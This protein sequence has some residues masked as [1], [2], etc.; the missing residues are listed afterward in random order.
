MFGWRPADGVGNGKASTW[1]VRMP[2]PAPP[3]LTSSSPAPRPGTSMRGRS[4]A[5]DRAL[6]PGLTVEETMRTV[7]E[8]LHRSPR[9]RAVPRNWEKERPKRA[10]DKALALSRSILDELSDR[11]PDKLREKVERHRQAGKD[12]YLKFVIRDGLAC[13]TRSAAI[14]LAGQGRPGQRARR[15]PNRGWAALKVTI[16]ALPFQRFDPAKLPPREWLYGGHYQRGIITA[17]V[18]PGAAVNRPWTSSSSSPSAPGGPCSGSSRR[19]LP[20]LVPQRRGRHRRDLSAH[21]RDLPALRDR[22]GRARGWLFVTSGIDHADQDRHVAQSR[23]GALDAATAAAIIR[24]IT[25]NEIGVVSFDPLVAHHAATEN[26]TGDMDHGLPRV[27]PHRQRHRLRH[28]DRAP[29]AQAGARTGGAQC[30]DSRGAGA[31]INAVRSARVLNTMS[32]SEADKA[33][34]DDVDRRLHFRIDRGKAN[35]APPRPQWH[36]FESVDLPNGDNVGVVTAWQY[37]GQGGASDM[38]RGGRARGR[39][40]FLALLV[41]FTPEGRSVSASVGSSYAPNVF[42]REREAKVAKVSKAPWPRPCAAIRGEADPRRGDRQQR[43][44]QGAPCH[45]VGEVD[46]VGTWWGPGGGRPSVPYKGRPPTGAAAR[47]A[48]RAGSRGLRRQ[49]P[50]G[51]KRATG[52]P[53]GEKT[54]LKQACS[55][56]R[57]GA[58]A[59]LLSPRYRGRNG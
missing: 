31:I 49:C 14:S 43:Q 12:P 33:G 47:S 35:M 54:F 2:R 44:A 9:P 16:E 39:A 41:R 32:K 10:E 58:P 24:T 21:C 11:L 27:R 51:N 8:E 29:H 57:S 6:R 48:E 1:N 25:D 40:R 36:K 55:P 37:P 7:L 22:P 17:T 45:R 19:A 56:D 15:R 42:A 52:I 23:H 5:G 34:I 18:G 28:R 4:G 53:G 38:T 59:L 26:A 30:L 13:P 46:V 3:T 50:H 20:G